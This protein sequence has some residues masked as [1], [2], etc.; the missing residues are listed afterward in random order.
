LSFDAD[1]ELAFELT[2]L[3]G[4][5]ALEPFQSKRFQVSRKR[6]GSLVTEVDRAVESAIRSRLADKRPGQQVNGEEHGRS[7]A[8]ARCWYV[9]PIDGTHRFVRG[10]QTWMTLIALSVCGEVVLGVVALPALA[11][12]WWASRG[13]GAFHD[14]RRLAVSS[15]QP[16]TRATISDD[17][18]GVCGAAWSILRLPAWL[19]GAQRR[20]LT[21]ATL[22][23]PWRRAQ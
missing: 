21:R 2:D 3:A 12:R 11:E 4:R 19:R 9:D 10:D 5:V 16:L 22:S 6:D 13:E 18:R 8:S 1:L 17:W 20:D 7:G 23:S 14:G 15:T